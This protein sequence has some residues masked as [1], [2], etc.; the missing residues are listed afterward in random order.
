MIFNP[1]SEL[2]KNV[3]KQ[4]E[5]DFPDGLVVMTSCCQCRVVQV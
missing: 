1:G 4:R 3:Y 5:E 2:M